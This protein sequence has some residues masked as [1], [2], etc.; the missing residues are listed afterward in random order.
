MHLE[1]NNKGLNL[2]QSF[3]LPFSLANGFICPGNLKRGF[4]D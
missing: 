3:F 2:I 4:T 1:L